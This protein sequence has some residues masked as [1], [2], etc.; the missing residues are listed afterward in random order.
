M[1][2][3]LIN[4]AN[5]RF[6]RLIANRHLGDGWWECAC[7]CGTICKCNSHPLRYGRAISC[8][9]LSKELTTNAA[10]RHPEYVVW[11]SMKAR[12]YY[13]KYKHYADYGG[14][15]IFVCERWRNDFWAFL[16]DMG[17]RPS[18]TMTL[19]RIDNNGP[20]CPENCRWATRLEQTRNRRSRSPAK[21]RAPKV[22]GVAP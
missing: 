21:G 11:K 20:Y 15:G 6:G 1:G 3:P 10:G 18:P 8:G 22:N 19:E 16:N 7:D 12:C 14:R 5:Q 17:S 13:T 9:C 4:I 2:M